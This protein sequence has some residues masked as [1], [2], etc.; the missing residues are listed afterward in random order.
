MEIFRVTD[1]LIQDVIIVGKYEEYKESLNLICISYILKRLQNELETWSC[2]LEEKQNIKKIIFKN[3]YERYG[4]I[5]YYDETK[6]CSKVSFKKITIE[7]QE[8]VNN[9]KDEYLKFYENEAIISLKLKANKSSEYYYKKAYKSLE[10]AIHSYYL[11]NHI[12]NVKKILRK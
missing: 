10:T 12:D 3:I 5:N 4:K 7:E 9:L 2:N 8:Y 6:L 1:K 11:E